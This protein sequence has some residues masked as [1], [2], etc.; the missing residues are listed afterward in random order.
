MKQD[1]TAQN[2]ATLA[3]QHI[4]YIFIGPSGAGKTS[5]ADYLFS[6]EQKVVSHTTRQP[7]ANEINGADYF[8]ISEKQF[9]VKIHKGHFSEYDL[10][11]GQ[12]YGVTRKELDAKLSKSD[13][14]DVLTVRGFLSLEQAYGSDKI[15]PVLISVSEATVI[16]RLKK[17][18]ESTSCIETRM[19]QFANEVKRNSILMKHHNLILIDGDQSLEDMAKQFHQQVACR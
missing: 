13:C 7:R 2:K 15:I 14:Y 9:E 6:K 1:A 11:D 12:Y 17:R 10:Y 19:D 3:K 5:L 4:C 8:F 16:E 18:G